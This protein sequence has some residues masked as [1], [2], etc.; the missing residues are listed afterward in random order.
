M[1]QVVARIMGGLGNQLF[2]YSAAR[3]LALANDAELVLD[4]V[5]GF[6]R[7]RRYRRRF[8]LQHF[9]IPVRLATAAERLEPLERYRR[10]V[11]RWSSSRRPFAAR[12][13]LVQEGLDFDPRLLAYR[14]RG[15]VYLD[16]YWQSEG[17]FHDVEATIRRDLAIAPPEDRGN[18]LLAERIQESQ[19]VA[20]HVRWFEQPGS[21]EGANASVSYYRRA[22]A[23]MKEQVAS[24]TYFLF[25]DDPAR[26]CERLGLD[27]A[28]VTVVE[29]NQG[30]AGAYA[31]LWL[32][33]QCRHFI[34]ANST[35]SWWGA[36]LGRGEGKIVITPDERRAGLGAW[37][38]RGL[39]PDGW[40]RL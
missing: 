3:R 34:T 35:F 6:V 40:V 21:E 22:M 24:A 20:L 4:H 27:R 26:A 37:G 7:D 14:V 29:G 1:K 38:F 36:W 8:M 19:A 28:R 5:S 25:S 9:G 10:G 15:R 17:Y 16:G 2:C 31:D 30:D 13:Y 23:F 32:M 33:A 11:L 18:R 12:S 39:V